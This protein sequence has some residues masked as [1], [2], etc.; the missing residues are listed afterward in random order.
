M[1]KKDLNTAV[2]AW[3]KFD[4]TNIYVH[5]IDNEGKVLFQKF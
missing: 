5:N 2:E 1:I 4:H 3:Q